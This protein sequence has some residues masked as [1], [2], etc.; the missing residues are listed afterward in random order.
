MNRNRSQIKEEYNRWMKNV[1]VDLLKVLKTMDED[2]IMDSFYKDL[3][4]GTGGLRGLMGAGTNRMNNYLVS[5]ATTGFANW[6]KKNNKD[7]DLSVAI[8][9]D[10]RNN[11][12][13]FAKIS[14]EVLSSKGVKSYVFSKPA[15][16]P[17]LS[18][19][20]RDLNCSGGI[21]ITASHNPSGYNGYK[22]Y[23]SDGTQAVPKVANEIM[24][25]IKKVDYFDR[26]EKKNDMINT[27]PEETEERFEKIIIDLMNDL[28]PNSKPVKVLYSPLHGTGHPYVT[29]VL[30]KLG[31][32]ISVVKE[33][34][35]PDGDFPT[36]EY[37]N[38]EDKKSF[39]LSLKNAEETKPD[40]IITTDPDCDRMGIMCL[41]DGEYVRLSGNEIG[42][43]LFNYLIEKGKSDK[44]YYIVKTIV[45][46][47]LAK[48]MA[49]NNNIELKETLTGFKFIGELIEKNEQAGKGKF[50]FG[51]E[52]SFG[53]LYGTHV[54]DKDAV[55]A[56][57][58]VVT[59]V[60]QIKTQGENVLKKLDKI[61]RK[62]G[63]YGN[64]LLSFNFE[65][66][67]GSKKIQR[68]MK[69]FREDQVK[70][71]GKNKL[72][73]KTD[74]LE[75]VEGLP[76]SNV[77]ELKYENDIKLIVRPSGTEPKIKFYLMVKA[78]S[79]EE[80]QIKLDTLEKM[81]KEQVN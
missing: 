51:F 45:T 32:K 35:T 27:I 13:E 77:I 59:M 31:H 7:R 37:P 8:A 72:I 80:K 68:I 14:S 69:N 66:Y 25:E 48:E 60:S 19:A 55:V 24:S 67:E 54:R 30:R 3:E 38:P 23:T 52:E 34:I 47:D 41:V 12:K 78:I 46:T 33:Q 4:F 36:L 61:Y 65:G 26:N 1:E 40:I 17:L 56:S 71:V 15:P 22:V 70:I 73:E 62:Y 75:G 43:L 53:Y 28:H 42:V 2:E 5:K 50:L 57:A 18:F 49:R 39:A 44:D 21:V 79:E 16:T 20:V 58:L 63:Y 9:F 64:K 81:V 10:T 29:D 6:L 11:S 74:Y 76:K